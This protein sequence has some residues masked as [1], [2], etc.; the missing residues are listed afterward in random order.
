MAYDNPEINWNDNEVALFQTAVSEAVIGE[1]TLEVET[2]AFQIAPM[3][4]GPKRGKLKASV[5][6]EMRQDAEGPYGIVY[7]LWYGR[8]LDP[9]ASQLHRLYPFLPTALYTVCAGRRVYL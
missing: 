7:S 1:L 4:R 9:K 2:L 3:S 5:G 8:F 6:S